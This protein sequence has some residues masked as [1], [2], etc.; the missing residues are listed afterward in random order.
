MNGG[1]CQCAVEVS[2]F[3]LVVGLEVDD[4]VVAGPDVNFGHVE[5]NLDIIM[6][7]CDHTERYYRSEAS[8]EGDSSADDDHD[9]VDDE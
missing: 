8:G 1:S 2:L 3:G 6:F 4:L 9:D 5:D 7:D